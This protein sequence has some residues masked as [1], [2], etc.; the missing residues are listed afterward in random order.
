M[1]RRFRAPAHHCSHAGELCRCSGL[2]GGEGGTVGF[3][4]PRVRRQI[5]LRKRRRRRRLRR[6]PLLSRPQ[7]PS[8]AAA[9][10]RP[11]SR[12]PPPRVRGETPLSRTAAHRIGQRI[13]RVEGG[14]AHRRRQRALD[15]SVH[16]VFG[17]NA[18]DAARVAL[19]GALVRL[20]PAAATQPQAQQAAP[21]PLAPPRSAV[22]LCVA[23]AAAAP[24]VRVWGSWE[25]GGPAGLG[26]DDPR[27]GVAE[28]IGRTERAADPGGVGWL[29]HLRTAQ[30]GSVLA[31]EAAGTQG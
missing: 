12:P 13:G 30:K 5:R 31:I 8:P 7:P 21:P 18:G 25:E 9:P 15:E 4:D 3:L 1:Q 2:A 11:H 29:R 26:L 23:P 10:R 17:T 14:R 27:P 6:R 19:S 22:A 24:R 16:V 20:H 28:R